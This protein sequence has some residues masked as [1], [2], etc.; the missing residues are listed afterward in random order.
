MEKTKKLEQIVLEDRK[1]IMR[2]SE[3]FDQ[4]V[5]FFKNKL[6]E[7]SEIN[8]RYAMDIHTLKTAMKMMEI[9]CKAGQVLEKSKRDPKGA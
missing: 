6:N 1:E 2:F 5:S 8:N 4:T 3:V 9:N 7:Q